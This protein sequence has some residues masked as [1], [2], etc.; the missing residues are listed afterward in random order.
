MIEKLLH[1]SGSMRN[2][3]LFLSAQL[4]KSTPVA[5]W[6]KQRVVAKTIVATRLKTNGAFDVAFKY[7][8]LIPIKE[9]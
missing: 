2:V 8:H 7:L 9:C 4:R 1:R 6:N 5:G 3:I